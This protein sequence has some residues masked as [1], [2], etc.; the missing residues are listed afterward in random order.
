[1]TSVVT[2]RARARPHGASQGQP[3]RG[4]RWLLAALCLV[5]AAPVVVVVLRLTGGCESKSPVAV[6]AL[7]DLEVFTSWLSRNHAQGYV[8]EVGWPRSASG[9]G[10]DAVADSWFERADASGLW[11]TLWAAGRWWPRSYRMAAIRLSGVPGRPAEVQ[12]QG[13]LLARHPGTGTLRGVVLP[14]GSFGSGTDGP[15]SY[16]GSRP[17][18]YGR[19]YYYEGLTDF[20]QLARAGVSL[21]RLSFSWERVQHVP[22]GPLDAREVGRLRSALQAAAAAG[23]GVVLDLHNYGDFWVA[24]D[25]TGHRRLVLGGPGLPVSALGD[26]WARL[27]RALGGASSLIGYGLMNEPVRLSPDPAAGARVW[28]QASQQA[29]DA[30]RRAGGQHTVLVSGYGGA[31]PS[32]WTR[33]HPRAWVDDPLGE[34]RYEAHQYFDGDRTGR[35]AASFAVESRQAAQAGYHATCAQPASA[36][37]PGR[38]TPSHAQ[39]SD[40]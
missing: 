32:M 14:S 7:R 25:R 35:Y 31:T 4:R 21:V 20:R 26:V 16:S 27:T 1:M 10:W 11:V 13:A 36:S 33:Y 19:D 40:R 8:G 9:Q 38:G 17:G 30:I 37:R 5:L 18:V 28:Q 24:Q 22:G 3:R 34:V 23:V 39:R 6:R 15:A 12:Q 29:V 2:P